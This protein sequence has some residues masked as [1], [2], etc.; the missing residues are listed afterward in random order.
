MWMKRVCVCVS[1]NLAKGVFY[2]HRAYKLNESSH[3]QL[4]KTV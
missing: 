3:I 1:Y 2:I 4:S